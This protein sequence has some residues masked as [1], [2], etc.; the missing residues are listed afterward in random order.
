MEFLL[1]VLLLGVFVGPSVYRLYERYKKSRRGETVPEQ[2]GPSYT[3]HILGMLGPVFV[4]LV[5]LVLLGIGLY[6]LTR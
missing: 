5:F 1:V 2:T 6:A 3:R 4:L